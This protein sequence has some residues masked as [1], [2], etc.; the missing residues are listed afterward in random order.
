TPGRSDSQNAAAGTNRAG[1]VLLRRDDAQGNLDGDVAARIAHLATEVAS[2]H[3][4]PRVH[5]EALASGPWRLM[6]AG[7]SSGA[8]ERRLFQEFSAALASALEAMTG[9]KASLSWDPLPALPENAALRVRQPFPPFPGAIWIGAGDQ[10]WLIA[11]RLILQAA[12]IDGGDAQ[13][14]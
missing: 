13:D 10:D 1:H 12:G 5:G 11:G 9:V 8:A 14:C 3:A 6:P 4:A 7:S 2:D